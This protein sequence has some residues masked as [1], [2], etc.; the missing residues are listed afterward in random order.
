M[1]P[2]V[3]LLATRVLSGDMKLHEALARLTSFRDKAT[4]MRWFHSK[5]LTGRT[6]RKSFVS[7][8]WVDVSEDIAS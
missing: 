4:L 1:N 2:E 5:Q 3:G 7:D 6:L 8:L